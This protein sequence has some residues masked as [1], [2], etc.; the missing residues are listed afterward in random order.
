VL[1]LQQAKTR[2]F[3]FSQEKL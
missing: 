2:I 1:V 3:A